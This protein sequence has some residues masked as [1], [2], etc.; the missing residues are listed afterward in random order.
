MTNMKHSLFIFCLLIVSNAALTTPPTP[1]DAIVIE[2]NL[3]DAAI[4]AADHYKN[5]TRQV[6]LF[7][8]CN[9]Q[10][11]MGGAAGAIKKAMPAAGVADDNT[12][13]NDGN[14][15]GGGSIAQVTTPSGNPFLVV[16]LYTQRYPGS[17]SN[18]ANHKALIDKSLDNLVTQFPKDKYILVYPQFSS[19]IAGR[20]WTK[21]ILPLV[22]KHLSLY[23]R[24][25]VNWN[26]STSTQELEG[27]PLGS[28]K[29][30]DPIPKIPRSKRSI[31]ISMTPRSLESTKQVEE[32]WYQTKTTKV[33]G[34]VAA[35]AVIVSAVGLAISKY[36]KKQNTR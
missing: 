29:I 34:G 6:V 8:S 30:G 13:K 35:V 18:A 1:L 15:L 16:N 10:H 11:A 19:A 24:H 7:H 33:V 32:K 20:D 28:F 26:N 5:D 36:K 3:V 21:D 25:Q 23:E 14:Y 9:I 27:K 17:V 22:N 31:D 12:P 2:G 4:N